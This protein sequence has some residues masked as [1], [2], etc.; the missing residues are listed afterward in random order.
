MFQYWQSWEVLPPSSGLNSIGSVRDLSLQRWRTSLEEFTLQLT[1]RGVAWPRSP[2]LICVLFWEEYCRA[3]HSCISLPGTDLQGLSLTPWEQGAA[4]FCF[5]AHLNYFSDSYLAEKT[6][7]GKMSETEDK[8]PKPER[9]WYTCPKEQCTWLTHVY[10]TQ[11]SGQKELT[12]LSWLLLGLTALSSQ[13]SEQISDSKGRF[14]SLQIKGHNLYR[15]AKD[16][17]NNS[18]YLS[19]GKW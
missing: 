11:I 5:S 8:R 16:M 1:C 15:G 19:T 4:F 6:V 14:N 12:N 3:E 2:A 17:S 7:Q 18:T 9:I 13:L 10:L